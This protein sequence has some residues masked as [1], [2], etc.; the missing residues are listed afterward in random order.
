MSF[1]RA[2]WLSEASASI[3]L[4][5]CAVVLAGLSALLG[6]A[7]PLGAGG[8]AKVTF[9]YTLILGAVPALVLGAPIY[10][11][12]RSRQLH[13]IWAAACFGATPGIVA[14]FVDRPLAP[15]ALGVGL[16]VALGTH[17]VLSKAKE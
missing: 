12:L 16:V 9:A 10:A 15:I 11:F 5:S 13:R 7:G 8:N 1:A 3:L 2:L 4:L 17:H 6:G 14:F